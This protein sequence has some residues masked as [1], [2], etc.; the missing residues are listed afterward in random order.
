MSISTDKIFF[1][2]DCTYIG[3]T[4]GT[5]FPITVRT[6]GAIN[7]YASTLG[8][9]NAFSL[10]NPIVLDSDTYLADAAGTTLIENGVWQLKGG[11]S[12]ATTIV[13]GDNPDSQANFVSI[14]LDGSH[15]KDI[16]IGSIS[17]MARD[18]GS[19]PTSS[20]VWLSIWKQVSGDNY[21]LLAVSREAKTQVLG[22]WTRWDFNSV[23]MTGARIRIAALATPSTPFASASQLGC[24]VQERGADDSCLIHGTQYPMQ[25]HPTMIIREAVFEGFRIQ[26]IE[27]EDQLPANPDPN[28]LYCIPEK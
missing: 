6:T 16:D 17:L 5:Y 26:E 1:G 25:Y 14:E 11:E 23:E 24:K 13:I 3:S 21:E 10:D 4:A 15:F 7:V 28:T 22:Q 18:S 20:A 27:S 19:L 8:L 9:N 12:E 2:N